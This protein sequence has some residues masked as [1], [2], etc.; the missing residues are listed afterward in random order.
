[1]ESVVGEVLPAETGAAALERALRTAREQKAQAEDELSRLRRCLSAYEKLQAELRVLPERVEKQMLVPHGK[2]ATFPGKLVHTNEV[3]VLLGDNYFAL[4]SAQQASKLAGRR[5]E[6]VRPQLEAK[7]TEVAALAQQ[8]EEL[9]SVYEITAQQ[10]DTFEIREEYHS[11]DDAGGMWLGVGGS[12]PRSGKDLKLSRPSAGAAPDDAAPAGAKMSR[13]KASRVKA[14]AAEGGGGKHV[15]FSDAAADGAEGGG[16]GRRVS[17][18]DSAAE[19]AE[20]A[21]AGVGAGEVA[22]PVYRTSSKKPIPGIRPF[23]EEDS[24]APTRSGA[25]AAASQSSGGSYQPQGAAAFKSTIVERVPDHVPTEADIVQREVRRQLAQLE[26]F[27]PR[28]DSASECVD[29][30]AGDQPRISRFKATR[31]KG[32]GRD[33]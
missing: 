1:M 22:A 29:T 19:G 33:T 5:V 4:R 30:S 24:S 10:H 27:S 23:S 31:T 15:S 26:A 21:S 14:A 20:A 13:F 9:Q 2:M 3:M 12:G 6:W 28:C 8:V 7:Q 11:D 16:G 17:C 32:A 25:S 18:S